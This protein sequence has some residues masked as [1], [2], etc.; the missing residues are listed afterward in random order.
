ML[1][2]IEELKELVYD[3]EEEIRD[4]SYV[5]ADVSIDMINAYCGRLRSKMN[6]EIN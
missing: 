4:G 5:E 6:E 3:L 1:N 2:E